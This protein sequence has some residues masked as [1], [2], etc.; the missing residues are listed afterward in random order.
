MGAGLGVQPDRIGQMLT[1]AGLVDASDLEEAAGKHLKT[2]EQIVNI[3]LTQGA[4]DPRAFVEYLA[5]PGQSS[6]FDLPG[7]DIAPEITE[8]VSKNFALMNEVVPIGREGDQL[9]IAAIRPPDSAVVDALEDH[10]GMTVKTLL[11]SAA[12]IRV[13]IER[14]YRSD[15]GGSDELSTLEGPLKLMTVMSLL[16][17]IDS[18]P[19]LP[20][21]VHKVR[22]MLRD[23]AGSASEVG[24]VV[25]QDPAIAA[26]VLR[27]ANSAAYGFSHHVD[28]VQLAV[29]LLGLVETYSV[30]VS[31]AVVNVFERSRTFDYPSFWMESMS[32]AALAK[33]LSDL[34]QGKRRTGVF[35]AGLLHDIGRL[36]LVQIAP[37]HYE[38][39]GS[40]LVGLELIEA[41]ERQF[42][43]AHPEAGALLAQHWDLPDELE[44][45]IRFHH[46]PRYAND[47]HR[48][49]VSLIQIADVLARTHGKDSD[50]SA[51]DLEECETS[52]NYLGLSI[53][54]VLDVLTS[55]PKPSASDSLWSPH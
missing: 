23:M 22:E 9:T 3:L 21:T 4:L 14:H 27:V 42:G 35:S 53:D 19:A 13:C 10:T 30:V 12:D 55:V 41:E 51:V 37:R 8:L 5:G 39:V 28:T 44:E 15:A 49:M 33:A 7:L 38:N 18:L 2:G 29:S 31:S 25:A 11:C 45:C 17:Q 24:E 48:R 16:R 54:R 52:L 20:R 34:V 46:A 43:I 36:A 26:K 40:D 6:A 1:E 50:P 47:E 32:C